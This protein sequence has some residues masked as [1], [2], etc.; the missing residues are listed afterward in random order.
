MY[1]CSC[2]NLDPKKKSPGKANGNLY[3]CK[4]AK[5]F[6]YASSSKCKN[7]EKASGRKSYEIDEIY[8]ESKL[9]D[10]DTTPLGLY[11]ILLIVLVIV[12]LIMGV[13]WQF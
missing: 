4:K 7:F 5:T 2:K 9:Y 13:F 8:K 11:V 1:C 3:F 6:V 12:G 10:N